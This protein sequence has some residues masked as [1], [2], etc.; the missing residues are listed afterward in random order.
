MRG[1]YSCARARWLCDA[2]GTTSMAAP[3]EAPGAALPAC[4]QDG[5]WS[6]RGEG[7]EGGVR[8]WREGEDTW[9]V[10][11]QGSLGRGTTA[12]ASG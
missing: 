3:E 10:R 11:R 8:E 9:R 2:R 5:Q 12:A 7:G 4:A 1:V 6:K